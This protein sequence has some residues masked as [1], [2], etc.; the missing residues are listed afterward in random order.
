MAAYGGYK[1]ANIAK[2]QTSKVLTDRGR[3]ETE[4][5]ID[6]LFDTGPKLVPTLVYSKNR[7]VSE[8]LTDREET[9]RMIDELFEPDRF[10][11][12]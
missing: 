2:K 12:V 1:A 4:R 5:M 11:R 3:E 9:E 7:G 6:E 10:F 8:S